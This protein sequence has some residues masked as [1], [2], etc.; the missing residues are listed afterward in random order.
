MSQ[1]LG[2]VLAGIFMV[3]LD[4]TLTPKSTENMNPWKR[5]IDGT[6]SVIKE[7]SIVHALTVSN[8]FHKNIEFTYEMGENGKIAFL[9]VLIIRNNNT[10]KTTG[11]RKTHNWVYLDRKPF[12][13][14]TLKRDTLRS[15]ITRAYR[16]CSTQEYLEKELL[17]IQHESTQINGYPKWMFEKI[18]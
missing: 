10:L 14:P 8:N 1:P 13:S 7:T 4:S 17:K 6:I 9:D 15:I 16:I 5:C 3:H 2:L 12:A 18:N 11:Y